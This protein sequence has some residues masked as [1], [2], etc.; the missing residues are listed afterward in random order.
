MQTQGRRT[1]KRRHACQGLLQIVRTP[2]FLV[3]RNVRNKKRKKWETLIAWR[4][5]LQVEYRRNRQDEKAVF[6]KGCWLPVCWAATQKND[7]KRTK[8]SPCTSL[9]LTEGETKKCEGL[10][11][12]ITGSNT[13]RPGSALGLATKRTPLKRRISVCVNVKFKKGR[14]DTDRGRVR[15]TKEGGRY[16]V[17]K[18]NRAFHK[19]EGG[20]PS[21]AMRG[22]DKTCFPAK[23][24]GGKEVLQTVRKKTR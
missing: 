18:A 15:G 22:R 12:F 16:L 4:S 23:L 6:R 24:E 14:E 19:L 1:G 13:G 2:V 10:R 20:E 7:L 17:M 11:A 3:N 5:S 8:N 21:A 9:W